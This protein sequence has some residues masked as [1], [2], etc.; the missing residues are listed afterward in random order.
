M[1]T[2]MTQLVA[3]DGIGL[4]QC[5]A[6]DNYSILSPHT[7]ISSHIVHHLMLYKCW[8]DAHIAVKLYCNNSQPPLLDTHPATKCL[9]QR[10]ILSDSLFAH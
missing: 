4:L 2:P 8:L 1:L 10:D 9:L 7:L 5:Q 3:R 6:S